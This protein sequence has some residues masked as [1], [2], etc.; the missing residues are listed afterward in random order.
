MK[1]DLDAIRKIFPDWASEFDVAKQPDNWAMRA[2]DFYC[3]ALIISEELD[4][5]HKFLHEKNGCKITE[6]IAI[7]LN[8]RSAGVFCMAFAI[9]LS[10]KAVYVKEIAKDSMV[11]NER[12]TFGNHKLVDLVRDTSLTSSM[13]Q[14]ELDAISL[15]EELI[16]HGKY[17][18]ALKPSDS[19][20]SMYIPDLRI[21][22]D[23]LK[24]IYVKF[25]NL[26][27]EKPKE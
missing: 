18:A 26:I 11:P 1:P 22:I 9:E 5:T 3:A 4:E 15:A 24:P 2:Q 25:S 13:S 14:D 7:R 27:L 12:I 23:K 21:L 6:K 20:E 16:A 17:P 10:I 8:G 19:A